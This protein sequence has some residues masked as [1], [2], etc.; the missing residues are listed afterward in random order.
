MSL[1][2]FLE[3]FAWFTILGCVCSTYIRVKVALLPDKYTPELVAISKQT[4]D[5]LTRLSLFASVCY[6]IWYK[7]GF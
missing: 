2:S 4:V 3:W 1:L 6:V 7:W 5:Q